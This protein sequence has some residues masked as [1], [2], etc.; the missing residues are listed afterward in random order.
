MASTPQSS[1]KTSQ[2]IKTI[3][4]E[5]SS[6]SSGVFVMKTLL[7]IIL[8]SAF[9]HAAPQQAAF[10]WN[11]IQI[12]KTSFIPIAE[13]KNFFGFQTITIHEGTL[14]LDSPS[15]KI[16]CSLGGHI[17]Y[18]NGTKFLTA[19]PIRQLE[20]SH[21]ISQHDITTLIA[22]LLRPQQA[23]KLRKP[24]TI[25]LD[26]GH[27][28]HDHGA[29]GKEAQLTLAL[30]LQIKSLLEKAG[31]NVVITRDQDEFVSL[32]NRVKIAN[33][34]KDAIL[35]S[36]HFNSGNRNATG[37][38]TYIMSARPQANK[39]NAASLALAAAIHSQALLH[40]GEGAIKDRGIRR[41]RFNILQGC[42]HPVIII[43]AGSVSY[44][45][46]TLPT[47]LLV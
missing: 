29:A 28:G 34:H 15:A 7:I 11:P 2:P 27:G 20:G 37:F 4:P 22:P 26:P 9:A 10:Q 12:G 47:I 24:T 30:A 21:Y 8:C 5:R 35:I 25:V 42:I 17:T 16:T 1:S 23:P 18:I 32:T 46:L 45:H 33:A 14:T 44:T 31:L 3:T 40:L 36:L 38:E 19:H 41:A 6:P 39:N 13:V 43:E